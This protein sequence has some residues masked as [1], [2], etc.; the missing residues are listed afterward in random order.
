MV[1]SFKVRVWSLRVNKYASGTTS[2]SVRWKVGDRPPFIETYP[3]YN[4]ADS[5]RSQL[6]SAAKSGE[7][8]DLDNGRPVSM[9][10][11]DR[12]ESFD[13]FACRYVEMK[14]PQSAATS[15]RSIAEAMVTATC[16]MLSSNRG[17]PDDKKV[18]SALFN[19]AFNGKHC[20]DPDMPSGVA[21]TLKW[22]ESNTRNV[23]AL[24]PGSGHQPATQG[25]GGWTA[26]VV[27]RPGIQ[28]AQSGGARIQPPQAVPGDRD[29]LRQAQQPLAGQQRHRRDH[30]L[31]PRYTRQ[32]R[33]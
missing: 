15:R 1:T 19:W 31:D 7:A 21:A 29:T 14:W 27:R 8:F 2:Y 18:R 5:F 4:Q 9:Q 17:K 6:M 13:K 10:R 33:S 32:T 3:N 26:T 20:D 11:S 28:A 16:A 23:S 12:D 25:I 22:V 24:A 30:R